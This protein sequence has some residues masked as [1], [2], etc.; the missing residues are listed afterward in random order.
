MKFCP[1]C[2]SSVPEDAEFC[3]VCGARLTPQDYAKYDPRR[4]RREE[5]RGPEIVSPANSSRNPDKP[6]SLWQYVGI[7]VVFSIPLVGFIMMIVWACGAWDNRHVKNM[8]RAALIVMAIGLVLGHI[9]VGSIGRL[10]VDIFEGLEDEFPEDAGG[11][12]DYLDDYGAYD[13]FGGYDLTP[14]GD[15]C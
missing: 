11:Y 13:E 5:P 8:A 14:E 7:F 1:Q 2:S 4:A 6:L 9:F 10:I 15:Y 3:P 12:E